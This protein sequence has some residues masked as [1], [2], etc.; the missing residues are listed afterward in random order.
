MKPFDDTLY[1]LLRV[2]ESTQDKRQNEALF[3]AI[4]WIIYF[5]MH[6]NACINAGKCKNTRIASNPY[7][8]KGL[9]TF[10]LFLLMT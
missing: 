3:F 8:H 2:I 5:L 10:F 9:G 1:Q 4:F 6:I 7:S